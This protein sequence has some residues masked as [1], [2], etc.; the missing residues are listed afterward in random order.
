MAHRDKY[1]QARELRK[2]GLPYSDIRVRLGV[3]KSTLS[4][5]LHD[6]PLTRDRINELRAY[7]SQR[8]E[9]FRNTMSE[10]REKRLAGVYLKVK[11]DIKRLTKRDIFIAGLFLY[12][13][14]GGKTKRYT[15]TLS[16][17][18]PSMIRFYLRWLKELRIP[19]EKIKV[20]LQLYSDMDI[21]EKV[22]FWV[23]ETGLPIK[24]FQ[25]TYVKQTLYTRVTEKGFGHGTCNVIVDDRD[26]Q[27]YVQQSLRV[28][29]AL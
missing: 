18:D 21:Q 12:W 13:G 1:I 17:T 8:I 14:E 2:Q 24:Q 27:E 4:A 3:S 11:K 9:R 5:W 15:I 26:I 6:M 28:I 22:M 23:K 7:S 20:R 19:V 16:N 10:K 25:K 29:A